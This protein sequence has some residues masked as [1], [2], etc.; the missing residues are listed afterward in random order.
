MKQS[1]PEHHPIDLALHGVQARRSTPR[2]ARARETGDVVLL[3]IEGDSQIEFSIDTATAHP[4]H[5]LLLCISSRATQKRAWPEPWR[6][7]EVAS[8][9]VLAQFGK[10]PSFRCS[11]N[12]RV[13]LLLA[14]R[15]RVVTM[16]PDFPP[17]PQRFT[18][19]RVLD[20]SV[21]KF[22]EGA[23]AT[24]AATS[25]IEGYAISQLATEMCA[26]VVLDRTGLNSAHTLAERLCDLADAVISQQ[27][28]DPSL[29]PTLV[30][31]EIGVALRT[32]QISYAESG[33]SIAREIRRHRTRLAHSLLTDDRYRALTIGEVAQHAGFRSPMSLRR[34]LDEVYRT[35]PKALRRIALEPR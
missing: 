16:A 33:S 19:R 18:E 29:T 35:T 2:R 5:A 27:C 11:G 7:V 13:L 17:H 30:A 20:R 34:A 31:E 24:D 10:V 8:S 3:H 23:L 26:A 25:N 15:D 12:W 22:I 1:A 28:R 4:D 32:L 21:E 14:P 6:E 9:L